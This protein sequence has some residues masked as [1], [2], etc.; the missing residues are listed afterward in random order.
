MGWFFPYLGRMNLKG[1]LLV[2]LL[3]L[4]GAAVGISQIVAE[5]AVPL[6]I[7]VTASG[8]NLIEAGTSIVIKIKGIPADEK[9]KIDADYRVSEQGKINLPYVGLVNAEGKTKEQLASDIAK[10]Y[11]EAKIFIAPAVAIAI[12]E[13]PVIRD[14]VIHIGGQVRKPGPVLFAEGMTLW[15]AIQ[16]AGGATEFGS[17]RR[18]KLYRDGEQINYDMEQK[19]NLSVPLKADDTIEVP[20]RYYYSR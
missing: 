7:S 14:P 15:K 2:A 3:A 4:S 13:I 8:A 1:I 5:K 20:G 18:V 10:A 12:G 6:T 17:L 9:A 11:L 16:A 19:E